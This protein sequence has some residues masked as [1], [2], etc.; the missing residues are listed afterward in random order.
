MI[1]VQTVY[2][3]NPQAEPAFRFAFLNQEQISEVCETPLAYATTCISMTT[4]CEGEPVTC[5]TAYEPIQ[6]LGMIALMRGEIAYAARHG[7]PPAIYAYIDDNGD[8]ALE[9]GRKRGS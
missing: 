7:L 1:R 5:I 3:A 6:V 4:E 2:K 8:I 9:R